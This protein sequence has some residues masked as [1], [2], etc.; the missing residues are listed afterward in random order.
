M[1]FMLVKSFQ[2]QSRLALCKRA[3]GK[4]RRMSGYS[5]IGYTL[6][7]LDRRDARS[8]G[9]VA[10]P[11]ACA[12]AE[13][14]PPTYRRG[15]ARPCCPARF[16]YPG[17]DLIQTLA[18][19]RDAGALKETSLPLKPM[20]HS[21][22]GLLQPGK[23]AVSE[24]YVAV[25]DTGHNRVV[26]LDRFG[27]SLKVI[28]D[29]A[30]GSRDGAPGQAEFDGPQGLA[31]DGDA[32]YV[33]DT[34]N[35]LIRMIDLPSGEVKTIAGNGQ[36]GYAIIGR[37]PAREVGLSS[38]WGLQ[39]VGRQLYIAMAGIHQVWRLDLDKDD[40]GVFAGSGAEGIADG[41]LDQ[42]SFA[43]SSALAYH[44]GVLYVADPEASAVRRIDLKTGVVET[45]IGK[46][47][48]VFGLS[49]GAA[50]QAL[51]QHDQ[52]LVWLGDRLYIADTF[53][54][55][56]RVL[57]LRA[58]KVSTL[59]TGLSQPGGLAVLDR[60]RPLLGRIGGVQ[61]FRGRRALVGGLSGNPQ[62]EQVDVLVFLL[63]HFRGDYAHVRVGR[64]GRHLG[65]EVTPA[66]FVV[67][68]ELEGIAGG[69]QIMNVVRARAFRALGIGPFEVPGGYLR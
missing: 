43:Q 58:A 61:V 12:L 44:E 15:P 57:D 30:R 13:R 23:V 65:I 64:F 59:A 8:G 36:Q 25:S 7:R 38:P 24:R 53:N 4:W 48:F 9:G 60:D 32:L 51:L 39:L 17:R 19:A 68:R 31:F 40:V 33:A 42:A 3:T 54:N 41:P 35:S 20:V 62:V 47:L 14:D 46:G 56:I 22:E 18:S 50:G 69:H 26:L 10:F 66:D 5:K 34:G 37:H 45:L 52:G 16:L 21:R 2:G 6:P 49:D 29:G 27:K 67:Q 63:G 1:R 55:A 28:G 11:R